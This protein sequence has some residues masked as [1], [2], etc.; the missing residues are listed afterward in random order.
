MSS[1]DGAGRARRGGREAGDDGKRRV[2][3]AIPARKVV[4][5]FAGLAAFVAVWEL[6]VRSGLFAATLVPRPSDIPVTLIAE[7]ERA[8]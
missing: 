7:I 8:R 5:G 6:A 3:A 4:L 2:W 1:S